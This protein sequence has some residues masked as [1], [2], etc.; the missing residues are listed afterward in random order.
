VARRPNSQLEP[1]QFLAWYLV[2][3]RAPLEVIAQGRGLELEAPQ[4]PEPGDTR[5]S[6]YHTALGEILASLDVEDDHVSYRIATAERLAEALAR[7]DRYGPALESDDL[8][9]V[10]KTLGH[11]PA[12]AQQADAELEALIREAS[13][14][15]DDELVAL[16]HRR[17]L[18]REAVIEPVM[19]EQRGASIQRLELG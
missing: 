10:A 11:R 1:I 8:D 4:L 7:Q 3:G 9:D 6:S 14:E 16:L 13:P 2:M 15:R 19:R 12:T 18:R 17:T 5:L